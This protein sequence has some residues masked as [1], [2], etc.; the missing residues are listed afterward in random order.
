MVFTTGSIH[1][2]YLCL[3]SSWYETGQYGGSGRIYYLSNPNPGS[4]SSLQD[5]YLDQPGNVN[6]LDMDVEG[7][8]VGHVVWTEIL[9]G[10]G[11]EIKYNS[12]GGGTTWPLTPVILASDPNCCLDQP[13]IDVD[14]S[15]HLHVNWRNNGTDEIGYLRHVK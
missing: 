2:R 12:S 8:N 13:R 1:I 11:T 5:V 14:G 6:D 7:S 9:T 3:N 10:P 15:D 4:W